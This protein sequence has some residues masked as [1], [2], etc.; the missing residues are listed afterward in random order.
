MPHQI[1]AWTRQRTRW[2]KGWML[3]ALV[4]TRNPVH[5]VRALG[6]AGTVAML[7]VLAGTPLLHLAQSLALL[8]WASGHTGLFAD[9]LPVKTILAIAQVVALAAWTVP[10]L[11]AARR[12]GI[13][14]SVLSPLAIAYCAMHWTAAWRALRHLV[15]SPFRWEKTPHRATPRLA[16]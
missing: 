2:H 6:G 7:L 3:T 1:A 5:T 9:D 12:R 11:V 16:T 4:H 13:A 8:M 10:A 14:R 15:D